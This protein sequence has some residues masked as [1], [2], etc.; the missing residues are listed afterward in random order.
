M[1][2]SIVP[3]RDINGPQARNYAVRDTVYI[4]PSGKDGYLGHT[5]DLPVKSLDQAR[6]ILRKTKELST[7]PRFLKFRGGEYVNISTNSFVYDDNTIHDDSLILEP[8]NNEEVNITGNYIDVNAISATP[9]GLWKITIPSPQSSYSNFS[10]SISYFINGK[11]L[12]PA[13]F[14]KHGA[15]NHEFYPYTEYK[16]NLYNIFLIKDTS[17][18][19]SSLYI[20]RSNPYNVNPNIV[21]NQDYQINATPYQNIY[22]VANIGTNMYSVT[23][24]VNFGAQRGL[25]I[26]SHNV[27]NP[28]LNLSAVAHNFCTEDG[29]YVISVENGVKFLYFKPYIGSSL[30]ES[31]FKVV[32]NQSSGLKFNSVNNVII[33]DLN[34]KYHKLEGIKITDYC[35][36]FTIS[37]CNI[38]SNDTAVKVV[39]AANLK[40]YKNNIFDNDRG[41]VVTTSSS[42]TNITNNIL[43]YNGVTR[44]NGEGSGIVMECN[45]YRYQ[46]TGSTSNISLRGA[47]AKSF[48]L[49]LSSTPNF[50]GSTSDY[51][52]LYSFTSNF[53]GYIEVISG[54]FIG[55]KR[56]VG[57][58]NKFMP[59]NN[60]IEFQIIDPWTPINGKTAPS[61]LDIVQY[62]AVTDGT[63]R[64]NRNVNPV[65]QHNHIS[66]HA[67]AGVLEAWSQNCK[68]SGNYISNAG[69]G[70]GGDMGTIYTGNSYNTNITNNIVAGCRR[71]PGRYNGFAVYID[72]G[73]NI[74]NVD[75]NIISRSDQVFFAHYARNITLNNNILWDSK[76]SLLNFQHTGS[77]ARFIQSDFQFHAYNNLFITSSSLDYSFFKSKTPIIPTNDYR[78]FQG[79]NVYNPS[80]RVVNDTLTANISSYRTFFISS[81][82]SASLINGI[83]EGS[84][85]NR[86]GSREGL[87]V[88]LH[89]ESIWGFYVKS[90]NWVLGSPSYTSL[91]SNVGV[92]GY[93]E[94]WLIPPNS[95]FSNKN[96]TTNY[97]Y[98]DLTFDLTIYYNKREVPLFYTHDNCH[99]TDILDT[100]YPVLSDNFYAW[101]GSVATDYN[102]QNAT[103]NSLTS[104]GVIIPSFEETKNYWNSNVYTMS[105]GFDR[106]VDWEENSIFDN[107]KLDMTTFKVANDSP[108]LSIGFQQITTENIGLYQDDE[109]WKHLA[110]TQTSRP[111]FGSGDWADYTYGNHNDPWE[112]AI[113]DNVA[114]L[115][116][117]TATNY[118]KSAS[119]HRANN[120]IKLLSLSAVNDGLGGDFKYDE[121]SYLVDDGT[122]II[123]PTSKNRGRW[124]RITGDMIK[125]ESDMFILTELGN[126]LISG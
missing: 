73:H 119:H 85:F 58:N 16:N 106:L 23:A 124:M 100:R 6:I 76:G 44:S 83:T 55:Q 67:Y 103:Y 115:R 62:V 5:P 47:T 118:Y 84:R 31:V 12:V 28:T 57:N 4:S 32:T 121:M 53:G 59:P 38:M 17:N 48:I 82:L 19:M 126:P 99:Y 39:E 95:W 107:P 18:F 123:K 97:G 91:S 80:L 71:G 30:S 50:M 24:F 105:A 88:Y 46:Q 125:T 60:D 74:V 68:I 69:Y 37:G 26:L 22:D 109:N 63:N 43:S 27:N 94:P 56:I 61:S 15:Y 70:Y 98:L 13:R 111:L 49:A 34:F 14:P 66:H 116:A 117:N 52:K 92:V 1:I 54:D 8:H 114:N 112:P 110:N 89:T 72:A 2:P 93:P 35:R 9:Y 87:P 113:F 21:Y 11:R 40:L 104:V 120:V 33:K 90:G 36:N 64:S 45:Y 75:N 41:G 51:D 96:T 101:T 42:A 77:T 81:T 3:A 7:K 65:I 29:E 108:A 122:N 25:C 79:Y 10:F 86:C 78:G 20:D 102:G